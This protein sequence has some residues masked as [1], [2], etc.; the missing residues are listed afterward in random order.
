MINIHELVRS[1]DSYIYIYKIICVNGSLQEKP[2]LYK[3][4]EEEYQ[5][6]QNLPFILSIHLIN[7]LI[8]CKQ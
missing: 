1:I 7:Y 4:T 2:F 5:P 3:F 6:F 8:C